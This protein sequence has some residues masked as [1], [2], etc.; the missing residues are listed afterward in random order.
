MS[1]IK[2]C[3]FSADEAGKFH[4]CIGAECAAYIPAEKSLRD[5]NKNDNRISFVSMS[6]TPHCA[7]T[8][9][10]TMKADVINRMRAIE[11]A[12]LENITVLMDYCPTLRATV[13]A[14]SFVEADCFYTVNGD[15]YRYALISEDSRP[16][17]IN[18]SSVDGFTEEL[19][20]L[21]AS[22]DYAEILCKAKNKRFDDVMKGRRN[23]YFNEQPKPER[24]EESWPNFEQ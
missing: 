1:I 4:K 16:V 13:Q 17:P 10:P 6:N 2:M 22:P 3:P 18:L 15:I 21:Q 5:E 9:Q 24:N 8:S 12:E 20:K 19:S 14:F 7:L 23:D 11:R